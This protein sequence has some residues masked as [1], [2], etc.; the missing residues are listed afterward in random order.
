MKNIIIIFEAII[1]P[2]FILFSTLI[3]YCE[4]KLNS[5]LFIFIWYVI[6]IV[7]AICLIL[8]IVMIWRN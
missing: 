2:I 1:L 5:K 7:C 8:N 6:A 3:K 4:N